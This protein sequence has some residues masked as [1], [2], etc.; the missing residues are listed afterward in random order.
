MARVTL[1]PPW[2]SARCRGD[3]NVALIQ[4]SRQTRGRHEVV[5]VM[6]D[7]KSVM[8][9]GRVTK[10]CFDGPPVDYPTASLRTDLALARD[11][12][13]KLRGDNEKLRRSTQRL[14]GQQLDQINVGDLVERIDALVEENRRLTNQLRQ[15]TKENALLNSQL[16][17]MGG[18]GLRSHVNV[19]C[20]QG[21]PGR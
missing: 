14:L 5:V 17:G 20:R 7:G 12:I 1:P 4:V 13:K 8:G 19:G 11:E 3:V 2:L 21:G 16:D 15:T 10:D 9:G 18:W 6:E